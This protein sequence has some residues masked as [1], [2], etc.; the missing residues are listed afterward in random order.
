[1][2][3]LEDAVGERRLAVVDVRDDR[4]VADLSLV[5]GCQARRRRPRKESSVCISRT[6]N[7]RQATKYA[8]A[9]TASAGSIEASW[10]PSERPDAESIGSQ[11]ANA[12]PPANAAARSTRRNELEIAAK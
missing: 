10:P 3:Q 1:M 7:A 2:G 4:E 11:I 6:R 8:A 12:A 9:A 5:H